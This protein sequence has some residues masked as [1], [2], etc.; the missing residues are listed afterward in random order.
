MGKTTTGCNQINFDAAWKND[1]GNAGCIARDFNSIFIWG[2]ATKFHVCSTCEIEIL[3][4]RLVVK[5]AIL[6]GYKIVYMEGVQKT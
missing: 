1:K 4:L 2:R 5:T 6:K 3:E